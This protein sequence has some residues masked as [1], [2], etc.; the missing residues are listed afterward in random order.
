MQIGTRSYNEKVCVVEYF[1]NVRSV[2]NTHA[3]FKMVKGY[4]RGLLFAADVS[5]EFDVVLH[6]K[7]GTNSLELGAELIPL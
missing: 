2:S 5:C 6:C 1:P 3:L 7:L 4:K